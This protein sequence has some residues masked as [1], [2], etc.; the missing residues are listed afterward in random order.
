[1]K[2]LKGLVILCAFASWG[3]NALAAELEEHSLRGFPKSLD[4]TKTYDGNTLTPE[5]LKACLQASRKLD[6]LSNILD[7]QANGFNKTVADLNDLAAKIK[8]SQAYLDANPTKGINDDAAMEAR[9][10]R[11]KNHNQMV[12]DYN[13]R[14][15]AYEKETA[16]Y[17]QNTVRY[18]ELR[19]D[20][21][22][23]CATKQFYKEDMDA[24]LIEN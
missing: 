9:N 14:T 10:E 18:A 21:S 13:S 8:A 20:F 12:S 4:G 7:S 17:E 11:V 23:N 16:S 19:E 15:A 3:N 5:Q 6:L 22:E 24:A 1:M 2:I